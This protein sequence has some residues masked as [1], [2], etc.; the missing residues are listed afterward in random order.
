MVASAVQ[1]WI[2]ADGQWFQRSGSLVVLVSV[3]L[4]IRQSILQEPVPS[5]SIYV[6]GKPLRIPPE[7]RSIDKAF[8]RIAWFGIVIGTFVWGYGDLLY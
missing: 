1:S 4:E 5:G 7:S 8:H 6:E 2:L 3:V